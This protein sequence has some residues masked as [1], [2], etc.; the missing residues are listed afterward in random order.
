[1]GLLFDQK[2]FSLLPNGVANGLVS[3]QPNPNVLGFEAIV[4]LVFFLLL[5]IELS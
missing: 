1:M 5:N 4:E 3:P 2:A